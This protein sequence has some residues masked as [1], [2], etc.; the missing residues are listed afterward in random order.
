MS[1][2]IDPSKIPTVRMP[3][4]KVDQKSKDIKKDP[5]KAK[6]PTAQELK[7]TLQ[8]LDME[9]K[10]LKKKQSEIHKIKVQEAKMDKMSDT[11]RNQFKDKMVQKERKKKDNISTKAGEWEPHRYEQKALKAVQKMMKQLD[12]IDTKKLEVRDVK[13]EEFKGAISSDS[14]DF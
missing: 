9:R 2:P 13:K 14:E 5:P 7:K 3:V 1:N 10:R 6:K 8:E 4:F 12:C 11:Q